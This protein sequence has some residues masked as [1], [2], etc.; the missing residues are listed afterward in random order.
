MKRIL[1]LF[2]TTIIVLVVASLVV[3]R[4]VDV[5]D[6]KANIAS[7]VKVKTGYDIAVGGD[8]RL[9]IL[10]NIAL[11]VSNVSVKSING[12]KNE[13]AISIERIILHPRIFPLLRKE[14]EI[15]SLNLV[16]PV[17][18][19]KIFKD[20]TNNFSKIETNKDSESQPNNLTTTSEKDK[21]DLS[22]SGSVIIRDFI[23]DNIVDKIHL[24]DFKIENGKLRFA[25]ERKNIDA[26]VDDI[27][28]QT[29][30]KPGY[31]QFKTSGQLKLDVG[32][33]TPISISGQ[34]Q[35]AKDFFDFSSISFKFGEIEAHGEAGIDFRSSLPDGKVAFY[36]ENINLNPYIGLINLL[37]ASNESSAQEGENVSNETSSS[38]PF[39]W[40]SEQIDLSFLRSMNGHFSFKSNNIIYKDLNIG[41][42]TLNSYLMN[43]KLTLSLKEAE[44]FD[45]NVS[46]ELVL[47]ATSVVPKV[48]NKINIEDVDLKKVSAVSE[49]AN[50]IAGRVNGGVMLTSRGISQKELV[51][52]LDGNISLK[53]EDGFIHGLDL[54]GMAKNISTAFTL[55]R[56]IEQ[57]T[58]F[59]ELTCDWDIK[60]GVM[61]TDDAVL[62]SDVIGFNGQGGINLPE[63]TVNFVVSPKLK[64]IKDEADILGGLRSPILISGNLLKPNFKLEIQ[65]LVE[66]LVKNPKGTKDLVS[67]IKH[68]FENIKGNIKGE[69]EGEKGGVV[70]DI[71]KILNGF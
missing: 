30:L 19:F 7:A 37:Q 12:D 17:V 62:S 10:P 27:L 65:N 4:F 55:G 58:A 50:K 21:A 23:N 56:N 40:N 35:V 47:D 1:V 34:Y 54:L 11:E 5:N 31:N 70:K 9:M 46:G 26:H 42:L 66:D 45:G 67:Q 60:N 39:E 69:V 2:S 16:N 33:N 29:S 8:I 24:N 52:N 20:G 28:F 59:K 49:L 25:D 6:Y 41:I 64:S 14:I 18:K 61:R 57:Q 43:G 68:D 15:S 38:E 71:K 3:Y 51:S 13:D 44:V 53:V 32:V 48:R 22:E 36:F 63:L